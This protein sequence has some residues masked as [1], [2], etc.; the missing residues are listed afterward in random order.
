MQNLWGRPE[1]RKPR[2]GGRGFGCEVDLVFKELLDS[3]R[4][5]AAGRRVGKRGN[6]HACHSFGDHHLKDMND[7][8]KHNDAL[9]EDEKDALAATGRAL[10]GL[11]PG[12]GGVIGEFFT[13][14]IPR[15]RLERIVDYLRNLQE[16]LDRQEA[17]I[18]Q[19]LK[20]KERADLIEE[21]A[22]QAARATTDERIRAIASLVANGID[23]DD[24]AIVRKKRL[25]RLLAAID[26]D[27][28][29]ILN[30][31]GQSYGGNAREAWDAISMPDPAHLRQ[32][33]A[34]LDAAK[35]YDAGKNHLLRLGL[36]Q[37][38]YRKPTRGQ[39]PKFDPRKGDFE[40]TLE[41]SYLGR[42]LLRFIDKP[43]P[44]DARDRNRT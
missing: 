25:A 20:D 38:R 31:Y 10:A 29:M 23:P 21:G 32:D 9:D 22:Y 39:E 13:K 26:D 42:L 27:E 19:L 30:A 40:H 7:V 4:I 28:L 37:K 14:V 3:E 12:F 41:V 16:R 15:Q 43:S 44:I 24:A 36:L 33:L 5:V 6:Y 35:L 11:V 2:R 1:T 18:E 8:E 34:G 17:S